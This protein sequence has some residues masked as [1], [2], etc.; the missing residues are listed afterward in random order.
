MSSSFVPIIDL[1]PAST[2]G[3]EGRESVARA[4]DDACRTSGFAIVVGHGVDEALIARMHDVTRRFFEQPKEEKAQVTAVPGGA[5]GWTAAAA[6]VAASAGIE[7]A[8]D[9]CEMYSFSRL[10]Q[11]GVAEVS[12]LGEAIG[13]LGGANQW[14]AAP[15]EFQETWLA[16]HDAMEALAD[17][18]LRLFARALDLE[19]DWFDNTLDHHMSNLAANWY[20][21]VLSEPGPNQFRRGP[22]TDWGSLTILYHDGVPGLQVRDDHGAWVDAPAVPGSFVVNI[23]DLMA[24]WTNDRW[25]STMH[26]VVAPPPEIARMPRL[27][28]PYFHQ[29]N[30]DA[31]ISC[32][33]S[34]AS[35]DNPPH[36]A[37]VTSGGWLEQKLRATQ[38][39]STA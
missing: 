14:P 34:C 28:I 35:A 36:H 3:P 37:P 31:V 30:Y 24:V 12:G 23:G 26:R 25:V 8:P 4:L 19:E 27:S 17:E 32:I 22:H 16:Y 21:P 20:F 6:Y 7:T 33:P 38:A 15:P 10:G 9:L 29:P 5:R 13:A 18:L 11:P 1:S 39:G 2:G